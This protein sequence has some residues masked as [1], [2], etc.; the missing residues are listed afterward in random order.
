MRDDQAI[1][2]TIQ[3]YFDS[4][5]LSDKGKVLRAF[6]PNA[7]ITGYM[8]KNLLEQTVEEFANFVGEQSPSAGAKG[9]IPLLQTLSVDISG[10]TAVAKVRDGYLGMIFIDTLSMLRLDGDWVIYNK[11]FHIET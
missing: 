7:K 8:G 4:M 11:L 5:Y 1:A 2:A 9:E 3:T 6:H 10:N